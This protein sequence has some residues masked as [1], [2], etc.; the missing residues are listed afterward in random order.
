MSTSGRR[1]RRLSAAL[2]AATAAVLVATVSATAAVG[3]PK[4][5]KPPKPAGEAVQLLSFNDYHG[6]IEEDPASST[7]ASDGNVR[8]ENGVFVPAGGAAYLATH[9]SQLRAGHANSITVAAGDLIGGSTFTSGFYHDEPSVETLN[10]M[11]LD[12]SSV[13]NHEFDEGVTEL[14]R[15]QKGGCHPV[16]GCYQQ[17]PN[18]RDIR[19]PGAK[20]RW[21]AANVVN[22]QTGKTVLPATWTKKVGKSKIGFIGMTLE[23]TDSLVAPSGV[24]G[25]DFQD[26]VE[27][28][29]RAA[30]QLTSEGVKAIVVMLHEGGV[31]TGTYN[32]CT[33]I[34]GPIVEIAQNLDPQIDALITGHTHQPYNC[35]IN[36]PSGQPRK[37]VSAFSFGRII[38]EMNFNIDGKTHDVVR[39]SVTATNH[40]VTRTVAK[41]PVLQDIVSKWST[42]ANVEGNVPVG[43]I[44][45][46]ITRA[47]LPPPSTSDDRARESSLSNLIADAQLESTAENGSQIA[48]MNA[49]GVRAD[50]R[51]AIVAERRGR[52]RR[53]LPRGVQR[54]AVQQHPPDVLDD[55][56]ADRRRA[57]AAVGVGSPRRPR[58]TAA[59][60]LGRLHV[61]VVAVG[62]V[63][64]EGRP[65]LHQARWGRPRPGR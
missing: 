49:G 36:D 42:R 27:A 25:W 44:T 61:R 14:L 13:G 7:A 11:H 63:R 59:G 53:D 41:D 22:E 23:G 2:A 40:I 65:G 21:L 6:H 35:S 33:G 17:D 8:D 58:R 15:M 47:F 10:A 5:P 1:G 43:T 45:E 4:P 31:Q 24:A 64:P 39:D 52:R 30:A 32:G 54:A 19:Y 38:T 57:R 26:E 56:R 48:F 3:A 34:S 60:D 12:A 55:R 62:A 16:D 28:G 20:F 46:D 50:L 29:N 51:Y 18:G 37:V 9:L